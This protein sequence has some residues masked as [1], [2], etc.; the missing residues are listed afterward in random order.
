MGGRGGGGE[1]DFAV[2]DARTSAGEISRTRMGRRRRREKFSARVWGDF[3][4]A[5]ADGRRDF[6]D[7]DGG[8]EISRTR[9]AGD[10]SAGEILRTR[11]AGA[12]RCTEMGRRRE[13]FSARGWDVGG[14][15]SAR[16]DATSAGE[17]QRAGTSAGAMR[18]TSL[19]EKIRCGTELPKFGERETTEICS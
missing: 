7:A 10:T 5:D 19:G 3:A 18:A 6:A 11:M 16:G 1:G 2:A 13:K 17:I 12:I 14:R 15:N 8:G 4:D 9:M